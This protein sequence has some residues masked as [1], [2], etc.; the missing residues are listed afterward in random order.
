M[1]VAIDV[2]TANADVGSICQIGIAEFGDAAFAN[3]WK[4]LV[5]PED[6][7]DA[8]NISIH[9]IDEQSVLGA[10]TFVEIASE[11]SSRL[12]GRIVVCHT[13]FD[14]LALRRACERCDVSEPACTWI[15]SAR[16]ARRIWTQFAQRGY[17]LTNLAAFL[18]YEFRHHDALEDAKAAGHIVLAALKESGLAIN[19]LAERARSP[20]TPDGS[21][22]RLDGKPE[23]PLFGERIVFTGALEMPRREAADLA[24][25]LGCDVLPGVPKKTTLLVVG[26]QDVARLAGHEKSR[27]QRHAE[28]L[29]SQGI[30]IRILRES[31]FQRLIELDSRIHVGEHDE[32]ESFHSS[33]RPS[34]QE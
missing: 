14:R 4:S 8:M 28:E 5:D 13:A 21:R 16:V 26:D 22:M 12:Q 30:P 27:K 17:G 31:D 6:Y 19:A 18:E 9:G 1:F 11:V 2:E 10:P 29:I 7:F 15:D 20:L 23:G 34:L 32:A 25:R 24:A 3:G 33:E